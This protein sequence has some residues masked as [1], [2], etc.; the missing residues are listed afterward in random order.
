MKVAT[1]E[2]IV[3]NGQIRLDADVRLPDKTRVYVVVPDFESKTVAH[4][5]TPRLVHREQAVD[6]KK[7]IVEA[8]PDAG[9]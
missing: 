1:F 7:E 6:C 2:G 5:F 8:R 9:L 4:V 3:E